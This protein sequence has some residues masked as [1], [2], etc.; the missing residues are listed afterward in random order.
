MGAV[1]YN[2]TVTSVTNAGTIA[3][4]GAVVNVSNMGRVSK[5]TADVAEGK[6]AVGTVAKDHIPGPMCLN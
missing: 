5:G 3:K 2:I 4:I 6:V 1:T